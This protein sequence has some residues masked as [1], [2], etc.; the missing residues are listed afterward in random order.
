MTNIFTDGRTALVAALQADDEVASR[1]K[2]WFDFGP[3]LTRRRSLE[4]SAC[5]ALSVAPA[6]DTEGYAANVERESTQVLEVEVA[7]AGQDVA[8]CEDLVGAV[9]ACVE[10][11]NG[12]CLNL[13]A[14]GLTGLRIRTVRWAAIPGRDA[15]RIVWTAAIQ[16]EL[17]WRRF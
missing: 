3:G 7:A 9:M 1:V 12:T 11:E 4:P 14:E 8:P 15:A 2:T 16:V 17:L 10:T 5:P 6:Q 13:A